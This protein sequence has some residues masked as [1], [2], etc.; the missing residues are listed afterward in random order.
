MSTTGEEISVDIDAADAAAA[1]APGKGAETT[2]VVTEV[3]AAGDKSALSPDEGLAKLGKQLEDER[4]ARI[5][6]ETRA[7]QAAEGEAKARTE[8]QTTQLDKIKG[9]IGQLKAV[10]PALRA[11]YAA[12]LANQDFEAAAVVQEE[13]SDNSAALA[14]LEQHKGFLERQPKP[15]PR[16]PSDPVDE[17]IQRIG[18]KYPRSRAWVRAH[19]EFVRDPQKEKQMIAAHELAIARGYEADT[20]EYFKSVER[21]LD[22]T[23]AA[24]TSRAAAHVD[25]PDPLADS[26]ATEEAGGR[27]VAPAAAPVTRGGNGTGSKTTH[28]TLTRDE[29]EMARAMFPD[30]KSPLED[31]ARNKAALKKEGKIQ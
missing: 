2:T 28:M 27:S 29:A 6:A 7:N 16:A 15:V 10:K 1:V 17:Y 14:Q 25:D 30:S 23:P 26:S 13:M 9:D 11:K 24:T 4:A 5:A 8:V 12:A 19:P 21:T 22:I 18:A 31:Y 20:D 3:G